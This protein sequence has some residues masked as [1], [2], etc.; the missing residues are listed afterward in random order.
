M[1]LEQAAVERMGRADFSS[2]SFLL[3]RDLAWEAL[4]EVAAQVKP[5]MR[6]ADIQALL[7]QALSARGSEKPWHRPVVRIGSD[8]VKTFHILSDPDL[9]LAETDIFF[10]D[11]GPVWNGY[12]ADVGDSFTVGQDPEMI[13]CAADSRILFEIVRQEWLDSGKTGA[14]LYRFAEQQAKERGWMLVMEVDGHRLGDFP[15]HAHYRGG[16]SDVDFRPSADAWVLEIQLRHPTR[17]FGAFY[18]DLL[19]TPA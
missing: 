18:E 9:P 16:M 15:H 12:E 2:T 19:I 1:S 7:K 3:A 11:I 6:E 13:R 17:E 14:A 8:S 10:L 4:R 5:G